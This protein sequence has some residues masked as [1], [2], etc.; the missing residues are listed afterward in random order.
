MFKEYKA[1]DNYAGNLKIDNLG[2]HFYQVL[3]K[4]CKPLYP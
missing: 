4:S 1:K 2:N 3:Q